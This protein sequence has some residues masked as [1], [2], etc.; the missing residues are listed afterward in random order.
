MLWNAVLSVRWFDVV[1]CGV[2]W[3]AVVC[4]GVL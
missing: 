1:C 4:C 2:L 3:Y